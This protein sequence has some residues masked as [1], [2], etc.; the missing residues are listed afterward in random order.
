[1][2]SPNEA[3]Q[4]AS[5]SDLSVSSIGSFVDVSTDRSYDVV[6]EDDEGD[7]ARSFLSSDFSSESSEPSTDEEES[8]EEE[9]VDGKR[10]KLS[11]VSSRHTPSPTPQPE[12]PSISVSP[13]PPA[14]GN[15]TSATQEEST[16]PPGSPSMGPKIHAKSPSPTP[17]STTSSSPSPSPFG[18]GLGRLST[19]PTRSSPLAAK[20]VSGE[21]EEEEEGEIKKEPEIKQP[22]AT[23]SSV[24]PQPS[25]A[26]E[27]PA[28]QEE[29]EV[30]VR[31][32]APPL[33]SALGGPVSGKG[34]STMRAMPETGPV[35]A[36]SPVPAAA[37]PP[38]SVFTKPTEP[39]T[40]TKKETSSKSPS[41]PDVPQAPKAT[42]STT[43]VP[44]SL[45]PFSLAPKPMAPP[46]QLPSTDSAPTMVKPSVFARA[47][48][49]AGVKP[50][51]FFGPQ[52][53]GARVL[54]SHQSS[55]KPPQQT[56]LITANKPAAPSPSASK[57]Q[58]MTIELA[59]FSMV[60]G[61]ERDLEEV[62]FYYLWQISFDS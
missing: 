30:T 5:I 46:S 24:S 32:E 52:P 59:C 58:Q 40:E 25:I 47:E 4:D 60:E 33:L 13:S 55:P 44:F 62:R 53:T 18:V 10:D 61:I 31:P 35:H 3:N 19:R 20:P 8:E 15:Q 36:P 6:E 1:M 9:E 49:P 14:D 2:E 34:S 23:R 39:A 29:D 43:S 27:K 42:P 57:P 28:K 50:S 51:G 37:P 26:R 21:E 56:S 38:V 45:P 16:T 48:L 41:L 17:A 11:E 7:D 54:D 12:V 22:S